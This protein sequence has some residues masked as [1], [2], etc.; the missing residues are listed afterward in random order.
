VIRGKF[1]TAT[2]FV[3]VVAKGVVSFPSMTFSASV[4]GIALE[5]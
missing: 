3:V 5:A 4:V 2:S 1:N